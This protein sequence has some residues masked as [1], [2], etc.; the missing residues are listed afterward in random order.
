MIKK[1]NLLIVEDNKE[2]LEALELFLED[3]FNLS[4]D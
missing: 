3:E 1:G 2:I 4:Q